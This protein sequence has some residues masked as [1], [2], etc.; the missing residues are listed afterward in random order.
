MTAPGREELNRR[1]RPIN[2]PHFPPNHSVSHSVCNRLT[3]EKWSR[4]LDRRT[5]SLK[6]IPFGGRNVSGGLS[7][8]EPTPMSRWKRRL[9]L[10]GLPVLTFPEFHA[11]VIIS[12]GRQ[13]FPRARYRHDLT[14]HMTLCHPERRC[15]FTKTVNGR[16]GV[17]FQQSRPRLR[18][19]RPTAMDAHRTHF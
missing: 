3:A 5:V 9:E 4:T 15:R 2:V 18:S 11:S 14:I 17:Q 16:F 1:I 12:W 13:R 19:M 7:W 10:R 8:W 6:R